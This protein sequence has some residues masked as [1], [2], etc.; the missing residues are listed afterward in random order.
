MKA[1]SFFCFFLFAF[2]CYGQRPDSVG[3]HE[4]STFSYASEDQKDSQAAADSTQIHA[5]KFDE[6]TLTTL[7]SDESLQYKE[8]PTIAES[9]WDRLVLLIQ[10]FFDSLFSN[11]VETNWGRLL[12]Y[13]IGIA[14]LVVLIMTVLKVNAFKIFYTAEGIGTMPQHVFEEDIHEMDFEKLIHEA[15]AERDYRKGI[16]LIFLNSLKMLADKRFIRWEQ[17]KTNHDYLAELTQQDLK[18]G[19][20]ELNHYFEYAWYGNFAVDHNLFSKVQDVFRKWQRQMR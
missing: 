8:A 20:N 15:I 10:Q 6:A 11:A 7:K 19:F 18:T 16:R 14:I 4:D 9:L 1:L 13:T 3:V 2:L 5:R 12:S 17:G